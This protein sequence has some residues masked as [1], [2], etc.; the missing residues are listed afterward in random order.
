MQTVTLTLPE[1]IKSGLKRF[2]W[3][4]WS[5]VARENLLLMLQR[6]ERFEK[7]DRMLAGSGMDD[8][9]ALRLASELKGKVAEKHG[10]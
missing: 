8:A 2:S 1:E 10:L 9:A 3:V 7:F 6:Q 5:D 4:N